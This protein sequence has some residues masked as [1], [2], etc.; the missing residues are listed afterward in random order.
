MV[1]IKNKQDEVR[2]EIYL[3]EGE[4]AGCAGRNCSFG[5]LAGRRQE[6]PAQKRGCGAAVIN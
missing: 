1:L 5:E 4:E 2:E 6:G 3:E